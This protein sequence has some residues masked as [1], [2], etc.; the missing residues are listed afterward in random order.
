MTHARRHRRFRLG[1]EALSGQMTFASEVSIHDIGMGGVSLTAD[2]RLNIGGQYRLKLEVDK[3]VVSVTCEVAWAR[4]SGTKKTASGEVVPLYTAGMTFSGLTPGNVADLLSLVEPIGDEKAAPE[5]DRREH[6]RF[7]AGTAGLALLNFPA[8]Y[9]ARTISLGGMLIE[10][11]EAVECESRT[12]GVLSLHDGRRIEFVGRIVSC[13]PRGEGR[14]LRYDIGL[15]FVELTD[16]ARH[17]LASFI[18][19]LSTIDG[20][21]D[22]A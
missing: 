4:M 14:A 21:P 6:E 5:G 1:A 2:K 8:E 13:R 7:S 19:W 11:I 17:A 9:A 15:E 22:P 16:A 20:E 12:P 3:R 10:C 18:A